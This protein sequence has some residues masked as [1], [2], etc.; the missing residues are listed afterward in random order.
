VP[1]ILPGPSILIRY[2]TFQA[3]PLTHHQLRPAP[4]F[5]SL[6]FFPTAARVDRQIRQEKDTDAKLYD[7]APTLQAATNEDR[8]THWMIDLDRTFIRG[9]PVLSPQKEQ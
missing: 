1:E 9:A 8:R 2:G 6:R 3:L 5:Q 7:L 4:R